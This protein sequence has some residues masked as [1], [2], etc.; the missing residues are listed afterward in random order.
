MA[1]VCLQIGL[2]TEGL[3]TLV[4]VI[5]T[6]TTMYGQMSLHAGFHVK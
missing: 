3:F 4:A 5:W 6:L 2:L 1:L